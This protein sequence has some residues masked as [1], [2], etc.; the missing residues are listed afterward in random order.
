MTNVPSFQCNKFFKQL[1]SLVFFSLSFAASTPSHLSIW[2]DFASI[3]IASAALALLM[4]A[5]CGLDNLSPKNGSCFRQPTCS[6][7]IMTVHL[8]PAFIL[9]LIAG[10]FPWFL[11]FWGKALI[12]LSLLQSPHLRPQTSFKVNGLPPAF[13]LAIRIFLSF[14]TAS[15]I[16][17]F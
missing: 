4:G 5:G 16:I 7:L 1:Y 15:F 11:H 14:C 6:P 9:L 10:H 3:S 8:V 13:G 12:S 2:M 17:I